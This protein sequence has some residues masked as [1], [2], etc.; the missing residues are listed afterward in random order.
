MIAR[1]ALPLPIDKIFSYALPGPMVPFARPLSRVRVPF[2]NRSLVG[3][4]LSC[5]EGG[6]EG[7][8]SVIELVD[9][10]PL[11][12]RACA[13]LCLWASRHYVTP[14]GLAL[15][16]A[17][18]SAINIEKHCVV[19]TEDASL[20]FM[21]FVALKKAYARVGK[22][23]VLEYLADSR[24][25]LCDVFTGKSIDEERTRG[26][27]GAFRASLFLASMEE[28]R[29]YYTSLISEELG[30]GRNVLV[31]LPDREI[32]GE[33]FY[34][35]FLGSFPDAVLWFRSTM[36]EKK[37]AE[38]YFRARSEKG[39]VILGHRSSVF[40]PLAASGLIIVERP[41]ED[42]YR[43]KEAFRFDAVSVAMKRAEIEEVP[44]VLGSFA[45]PVEIMKRVRE[46]SV[47]IESGGLFKSPP[48]SGMRSERGKGREAR[49]PEAFLA[50]IA[51][52]LDSGAGNV[53]IHTPRR[54][55]ASSLYC[56]ACGHWLSC[57]AC[58]GASLSYNRAAE[59]LTCSTCG[60]VIA[61]QEECTQCRSPFI[62]FLDVGAEYVEA[63]LQEAFPGARVLR[64]T[65]EPGTRQ[66]LRSLATGQKQAAPAVIVGTNVLSK[67]YGLPT[68]LLILYGWEDFLRQGGFRARE[69]MYQVFVN[70]VDA[71]DP[72]SLLLYSYGKEPFDP[73][74]F[75]DRARFYDDELQK[76]RMAEFPPYVRFYLVNVLKRNQRAGE[77]VIKAIEK[78]VGKER[79][80]CEM[81]G[82]I[83][84]KGQYGW[85]V[86]LK[87][88][89]A[90][91][92]PLLASL[93][94]LPGV[95]IEADPLSV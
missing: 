59:T 7:L 3:F 9:C 73:S 54:A 91:L 77:A 42:E 89:E 20:S 25:R 26:R 90:S 47:D 13:E 46:G 43:N 45:P 2:N 51:G 39:R 83:D 93:Y 55:Y 31:L 68:S 21:D 33:R 12:D 40:L 58:S 74:L 60:K 95:H 37:R 23:A 36:S 35:A 48:V 69:K 61:Y 16:Y 50:S 63:R 41:E 49:M 17:L 29:A 86:I 57:P 78:M 24:I 62:R 6:E 32:V 87:G 38:A 10:V 84:V 71:L 44:V 14:V 28:R 67:L 75:L 70:L 76:R 85:R 94:R 72:E 52:A 64:I 81:L 65:G 80:D 1:V 66:T 5:E 92:L 4:M 11:I 34:R 8:K 79:L 15:K 88:N 27:S 56:G 82:P 19:R 30:R 18:S 22:E 53:V